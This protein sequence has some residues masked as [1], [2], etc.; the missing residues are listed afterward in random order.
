MKQNIATKI[1]DYAHSF[2]IS[3]PITDATVL[4]CVTVIAELR[5]DFP[6]AQLVKQLKAESL[7]SM[8][9]FGEIA[10]AAHTLRRL[11]ETYDWAL[12]IVSQPE[13]I[14]QIRSAV[15]SRKT[16]KRNLEM[17]ETGKFDESIKALLS[18]TTRVIVA[19]SASNS[20]P[21][22]AS[23][24]LRISDSLIDGKISP[25]TAQQTQVIFLGNI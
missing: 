6:D 11:F 12:D 3:S 19:E 1:F 23:L 7:S 25:E 15:A 4:E 16:L 21:A 24:L 22:A 5:D 8:A 9:T 13:L 18:A 20:Y 10:Q 17:L 2:G 14:K